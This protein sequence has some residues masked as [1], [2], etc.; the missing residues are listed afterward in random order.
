MVNKRSSVPFVRSR[1]VATDGC[2][3]RGHQAPYDAIWGALCAIVDDPGGNP[4]GITSPI[5]DERRTWPP[6][7]PPARP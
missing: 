6:E 5:E 2:G 4:V 3:Y 7:P 1:R